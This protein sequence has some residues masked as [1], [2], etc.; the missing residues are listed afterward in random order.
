MQV[1]LGLPVAVT[2]AV[3]AYSLL[4]P[5]TDNFL[6]DPAIDALAKARF[7]RRF[8]K[9]LAGE[10][11]DPEGSIET[12][13][14]ALLAMIEGQ[15]ERSR[16]PQVYASLLAIHNAQTR[17]LALLNKDL[18]PYE[19][20][21][22]RICFEKGGTSVLADGYLVAGD[23]TTAQQ[24]FMFFYGAL[25]Q[26]VDD[27]EDVERDVRSGV[28]TVFGQ[29][30]RAWKLDGITSRTLRFGE[31]ALDAMQALEAPGAEALLS[32]LRRSLNPLLVA[33]AGSIG[34]YYTS[35]YLTAL[36]AYSPM[37]FDFLRRQRKD[38]ERRGV[39]PIGLLEALAGE[40]QRESR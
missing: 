19:V 16:Y 34:K 9:R 28:I 29:T 25:T 23:L 21:R 39:S 26:L 8:A 27:L 5:Y 30:A 13:I 14:C 11:I 36:E 38:L 32:L 20:D 22:L 24:E 6:D 17:S 37:P 35:T 12:T 2:P 40:G 7:S 15:F 10:E 31:R 18:S 3:F 4:Y 33:Q 1:V